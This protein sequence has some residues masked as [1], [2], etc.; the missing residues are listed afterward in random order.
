MIDGSVRAGHSFDYAGAGETLYG[1]I[2][3]VVYVGYMAE[4]KDDEE[5]ELIEAVPCS[6][7]TEDRQR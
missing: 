1:C 6:R 5:I 3:G 4:G 7:C 2:R